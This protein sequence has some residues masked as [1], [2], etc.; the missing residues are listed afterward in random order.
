MLRDEAAKE[1]IRLAEEFLDPRKLPTKQ[2]R[3]QYDIN[4]YFHR[5]MTSM[6]GVTDPISF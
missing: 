1:R 4:E 6:R 2:R 3:H 5:Q